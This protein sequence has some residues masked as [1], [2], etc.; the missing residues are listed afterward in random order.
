MLADRWNAASTCL[1][2]GSPSW[3]G[4]VLEQVLS[5][6][7]YDE[8]NFGAT[9]QGAEIDLILMRGESLIGVEIKRA[10]APKDTPSMRNALQDLG[11]ER[12]VAVHP[13]KTRHPISDRIEAVPTDAIVANQLSL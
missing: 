4:F 8:A 6:Q 1:V 9:H 2:L 13:G 7:V 12:M 10:D 5:T 3:E 11:R